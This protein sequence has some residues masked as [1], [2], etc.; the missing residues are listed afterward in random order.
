M[1]PTEE[2]SHQKSEEAV[3]AAELSEENIA[4]P[5]EVPAEGG[6]E[7]EGEVE[8][9]EEVEMEEDFEF[10]GEFESDM[11]GTS[12]EGKVSS[13]DLTYLY[14]SLEE[15]ARD[16]ADP[17][18]PHE[19]AGG[20]AIPEDREAP[21]PSETTEAGDISTRPSQQA[22]GLSEQRGQD[23]SGPQASRSVS[24][25]E[26]YFIKV[27]YRFCGCR[28][29]EELRRHCKNKLWFLLESS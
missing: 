29:G 16:K 26:V 4:A 15:M 1:P 14:T 6:T 24:G 2:S 3:D 5:G 19:Y 25:S 21:G 12:P 7:I 18:R 22:V 11:E 9:V 23:A 13:T 17:T 27:F 28:P 8:N 10:E 20:E